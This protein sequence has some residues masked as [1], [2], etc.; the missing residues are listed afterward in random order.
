MA[1]VMAVA[2][3]RYGQLHYLDPG[4]RDYRVGDWVMYP[5]ADGNELAQCVWA[6]EEATTSFGDLPL[7]AGEAGPADHERDA[8]NRR[9]RDE[10][11]TVARELIAKHRLPMKVVGVDFV[12]TSADYDKL[13]AIYYTAPHRVDFRALLT[14]LARMLRSRID[15]RQVGARDAAKLIG[16]I[17]SCGR[18]LCCATFLTD[19]EPVSLRLAKLQGLPPN[20]LQIAG[21]CGK[22]MC[23]L[24][25]EHPLYEDYYRRAP[26]VGERV[27][28]DGVPGKVIGHCVPAGS[29]RVALEAGE[30]VRCPIESVC[31]RRTA[32]LNLGDR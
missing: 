21:A 19:F 23:C 20:P 30:V 18:E 28:A 29:V 4:E 2:F 31:S 22:L 15:L 14:D 27:D 16:G 3:E 5:T 24:K 1:R 10:S 17:G 26:A 8:R 9:I 6:P 13:T 12:D 11:A 7:C 32:R 25:F